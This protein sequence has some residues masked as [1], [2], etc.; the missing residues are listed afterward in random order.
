V[1]VVG[2]QPACLDEGIGLSP[3]V[4]AAVD[5][6]VATCHELLIDL[7]QPAGKGTGK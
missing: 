1:Y 2:C 4:S 5:A 6:A 7:L 3:T